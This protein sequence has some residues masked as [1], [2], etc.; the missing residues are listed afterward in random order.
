MRHHL[1]DYGVFQPYSSLDST[2]PKIITREQPNAARSHAGAVRLLRRERP[3]PRWLAGLFR[4]RFH[5]CGGGG[6]SGPRWTVAWASICL[7]VSFAATRTSG[8]GSFATCISA[9]T[10]DLSSSM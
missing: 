4:W 2:N 6:A 7:R 9:G 5:L 3:L 10:A 1:L 8:S